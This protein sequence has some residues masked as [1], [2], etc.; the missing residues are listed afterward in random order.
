M[1]STVSSKMWKAGEI[2]IDLDRGVELW[3]VAME[4]PE[5]T[6]NPLHSGA[7]SENDG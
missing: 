6:E 4:I 1:H 5:T 2:C 7:Q 3:T